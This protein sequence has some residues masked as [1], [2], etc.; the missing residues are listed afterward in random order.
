MSTM[1]TVL[2]GAFAIAAL[3]GGRPAAA[4]SGQP[5]L[6]AGSCLSLAAQ[7]P[8]PLFKTEDGC[9]N[10]THCPNDDYCWQVCSTASTAA[11]VNGVCQFTFPGGGGPT[12]NDCPEQRHCFDN[13][14]CVY[15]GGIFGV[16]VSGVCVC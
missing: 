7:A 15:F 10:M 4:G 14:H 6:F 13:S 12:G 2:I 11:C 3:L 1:K 16:C 8:A 5:P 9:Y